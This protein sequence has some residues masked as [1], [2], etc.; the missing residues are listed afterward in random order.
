MDPSKG[1]RKSEFSFKKVMFNIFLKLIG[2][3]RTRIRILGS[4]SVKKFIRTG[5]CKWFRIRT[6]SGSGNRTKLSANASGSGFLNP[7]SG[8]F[9][10]TPDSHRIRTIR[11]GPPPPDLIG[12]EPLLYVRVTR[13][14]DH[15]WEA[16]NAM[17]CSRTMP[18]RSGKSQT[19]KIPC[20]PLPSYGNLP[21]TYPA[22]K[23]I[24]F[25]PACRFG[26]SSQ[27]E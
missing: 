23:G 27:D 24:Y 20:L 15:P 1:R 9:M 17:P 19:R 22:W 11:Y 14:L 6:W 10:Q 4:G 25:S 5:K 7:D 3:T 8:I 2:V 16:G 12:L 21:W 26:V 18:S 13:H